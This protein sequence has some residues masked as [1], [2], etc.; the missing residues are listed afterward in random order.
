MKPILF[1][2]QERFRGRLALARV[3]VNS[4]WLAA[5]NLFRLGVAFIVGAW[6]ARHLGPE[7]Y[8]LLNYAIAFCAPFSA[9]VGLGL[10]GILVRDLVREPESAGELLGSAAALKAGAGMISASLCIAF[11]FLIPGIDPRT[12]WL[13]VVTI[14]GTALQ[15]V[16]VFDLW[17]QAQSQARVSAWVRSGASVCVNASKV[18]MI[19]GDV[20]LPWFAAAAGMEL[21]VAGLGLWLLMRRQPQAWRVR[22]RRC[23]TFMRE[24]WLVAVAG[25]AV[26]IQAYFDQVLLNAM[27][28]P[29]EVGV[30]AAALRLIAVFS[31]IPMALSAAAAP[32][33]TRAFLDDRERYFRRMSGLY[34]AMYVAFACTW[35]PLALFSNLVVETVFGPEFAASAVLLP[36]LA[37]RLLITNLGVVR[38]VYLTNE[39]LNGHGT[40][41]A[42]TG[43][44]VNIALNVVLIPRWGAMGCCVA[45]LVS[46]GLNTVVLEAVHARGRINLRLMIAGLGFPVFSERAR[47]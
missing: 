8:G 5:D 39:R 29:A 13:V 30:Y 23:A 11:V 34:R 21:I 46:F 32:E 22:W 2:F 15:A 33:I 26:Q 37:W 27:R 9:L 17:F 41:T 42:I 45:A 6:V 28:G 20:P 47:D 43:A 44:A 40:W 12:Q 10:N 3:L 16:D 18:G 25:I 35:V 31:F 38:S 19:L 1:R 7:R 24:G 4:A 36:V 14:A